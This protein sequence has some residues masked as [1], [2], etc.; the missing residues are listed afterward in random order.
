MSEQEKE[1]TLKEKVFQKIKGYYKPLL[2]VAFIIISFLLAKWITAIGYPVLGASYLIYPNFGEKGFE[3]TR[4]MHFFNSHSNIYKD[5][6]YVEIPDPKNPLENAKIYLQP[7]SSIKGIIGGVAQMLECAFILPIFLSTTILRELLFSWRGYLLIIGA[8]LMGFITGSQGL[9]YSG[10]SLIM[11]G[12]VLKLLGRVFLGKYGA[13]DVMSM[14]QKALNIALQKDT[15]LN[16]IDNFK[17][18][19]EIK[20]PDGARSYVKIKTRGAQISPL[21]YVVGFFSYF[22]FYAGTDKLIY[23]NIYW[24][25]GRGE[26]KT[27]KSKIV[28]GLLLLLVG[29]AI[30]ALIVCLKNFDIIYSIIGGV[31]AILLIGL[32]AIPSIKNKLTTQS[33]NLYYLFI[34]NSIFITIFSTIFRKQI[35]TNIA[36]IIILI[37]LSILI[38]AKGKLLGDVNFGD[39]FFNDGLLSTMGKMCNTDPQNIVKYSEKLKNYMK[40]FYKQYPTTMSERNAEILEKKQIINEQKGG[41][42]R[43]TVRRL[44]TEFNKVSDEN[45]DKIKELAEKY[46][47]NSNVKKI[48]NYLNKEQNYIEKKKNKLEKA[49]EKLEQEEKERQRL[50][51]AVATQ[52][53]EQE[54]EHKNG[55]KKPA[56]NNSKKKNGG[57]NNNENNNG[58]N[59]PVQFAVA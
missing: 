45:I 32:F 9:G 29:C 56:T 37:G 23:N 50:L 17:G 49:R 48:Q 42:I 53:A 5:K 13:Y 43:N 55:E 4:V 38:L 59:E 8:T 44:N 20:D 33:L 6:E 16:P 57:N 11:F 21:N 47:V 14:N 26:E 3:W 27:G 40:E 2:V 19:K 39:L 24:F 30:S 25:L 12:I 51:N 18:D 10:L 34:I 58:E 15:L 22:M 31:F 52:V 54:Q 35:G 28:E 1:L 41:N 7:L 46:N 36:L